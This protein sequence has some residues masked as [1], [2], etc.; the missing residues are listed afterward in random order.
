M[1]LLMPL[2]CPGM[3]AFS[4]HPLNLLIFQAPVQILENTPLSTPGLNSIP[5]EFVAYGEPSPPD[6]AHHITSL[7]GGAAALHILSP[8]E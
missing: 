7:R 2:P 6:S 3:K 5:A 4:Y 1:P 8:T